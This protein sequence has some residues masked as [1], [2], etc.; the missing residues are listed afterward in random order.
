M[1]QSGVFMSSQKYQGLLDQVNRQKLAIDNEKVSDGEIRVKTWVSSSRSSSRPSCTVFD[2]GWDFLR[3][4]PLLV[5]FQL[6]FDIIGVIITGA[7]PMSRD[8][9]LWVLVAKA[10]PGIKCVFQDKI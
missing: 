4:L 6:A 10:H 7:L 1:F 5:T 2:R 8:Y 3:R 9:S